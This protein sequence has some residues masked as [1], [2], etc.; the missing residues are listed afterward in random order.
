MYAFENVTGEPAEPG[1]PQVPAQRG[2]TPV[3]AVPTSGVPVSGGPATG[4]PVPFVPTGPPSIAARPPRWPMRLAIFLGVLSLVCVGVGAVAFRYYDKATQPDRSVPD[5]AVDNYLRA[6]LNDGSTVEAAKYSCTD[7]SNLESFE[8][9]RTSAV[10]R[11][12]ALGDSVA[13]TWTSIAITHDSQTATATVD[14]EQDTFASG[15][16]I[17]S[18]QHTWRFIVKGPT[19]WLVCRADP[20]A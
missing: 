6:V 18:S 9:F 2:G 7:R 12:E 11:A 20:V 19:S 14:V 4:V 1:S 3:S 10:A 17:A 15:N 8:A 5:V 16:L 13:F